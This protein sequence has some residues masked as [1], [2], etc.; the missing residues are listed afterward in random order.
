MVTKDDTP[1]LPSVQH[2]RPKRKFRQAAQSTAYSFFEA[3]RYYSGTDPD[4]IWGPFYKRVRAARHNARQAKST[5]TP[6]SLKT[7]WSGVTTQKKP[8]AV[9]QLYNWI[10]GVEARPTFLPPPKDEKDTDKEDVRSTVESWQNGIGVRTDW[11][12]T[13]IDFTEW[14]GRLKHPADYNDD[15][16]KATYKAL[17]DKICEVS[18]VWFG[19]GV[20]LED[21]R[22]SDIEI[23]PWEAPMTEQFQQYARLVAHEDSGY[24]EWKDILNDP[25]HRKWLCVSIFAQIIEKKI[26]STLL[27]GASGVFSQELDRHD[28]HWVLQEGGQH[29]PAV[30]S[31]AWLERTE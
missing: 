27:F 13:R 18:E 24:V 5:W 10:A 25:R 12:P 4:L 26:F 17:Y 1:T 21:L 20:R 11:S 2:E 19:A 3:L 16:Y 22:D 8:G 14:Y 9:N 23:S 29:S 31:R 6:F 30:P 28:Q 15:F 7:I